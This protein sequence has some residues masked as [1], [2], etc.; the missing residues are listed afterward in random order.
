MRWNFKQDLLRIFPIEE[1][2]YFTWEK[3]AEKQWK[4]SAFLLYKSTAQRKKKEAAFLLHSYFC[5]S[6]RLLLPVQQMPC[7][8][9]VCIIMR[10]LLC[11]LPSTASI[12][13]CELNLHLSYLIS[14]LVQAMGNVP[15]NVFNL[16][17]APSL[18]PSTEKGYELF[19]F[20]MLRQQM[21]FLVDG[22]FLR[23][24]LIP[25]WYD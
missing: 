6:P 3:G 23:Q 10:D 17:Q 16:W 2:H 13:V 22:H 1:T 24:E 25:Q 12:S 7:G 15:P 20:S 5:R 9:P 14:I 19:C 21:Y 11:K 18:L 4:L 8:L